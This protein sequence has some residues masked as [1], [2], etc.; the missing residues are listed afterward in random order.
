MNDKQIK[1]IAAAVLRNKAELSNILDCFRAEDIEKGI[2]AIPEELLNH[3]LRARALQMGGG[4]IEDYKIS[5]TEGKI[6][7]RA[8]VNIKQLGALA[9]EYAFEIEGFYFDSDN[10]RLYL[11]YSEDVRSLGG[12]LQATA[13]KALTARSTLLERAAKMA[14]HP[15]FQVAGSNAVLYLDRFPAIKKLP[16]SLTLS[17]LSCEDGKLRLAF[18]L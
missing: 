1:A 13:L 3:T 10:K 4:A 11:N 14:D 6:K 5:F 8:T 16:E 9:G 12:P 18:A 7:L 2:L 17:L 15:A